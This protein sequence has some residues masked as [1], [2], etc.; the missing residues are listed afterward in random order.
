MVVISFCAGATQIFQGQWMSVDKHGNMTLCD[1]SPTVVSQERRIWDPSEGLSRQQCGPKTEFFNEQGQV[2]LTVPFHYARNFHNGLAAV[3]SPEKGWFYINK[4]GRI[5]ISL[6]SDCSA[7]EDFNEGLAAV[8]LGGEN[9]GHAN[10]TPTMSVH[11]S[12]IRPGAKWAFIDTTGQIVIPPTFSVGTKQVRT[13][14]YSR[15]Y[16]T[17]EPATHPKFSEGLA[18]VAIGGKPGL[19][20]GFVDKKGRWVVE[21]KFIAT[22]DFHNGE[23]MVY[24]S[25]LRNLLRI[26]SQARS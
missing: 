6:P 3:Y 1:S 5:A 17:T 25:S 14:Y 24:I 4:S 10:Y 2:V 23:A 13:H 15:T 18:A 16:L 26:A 20:F 11:A 21:P 22:T 8:A 9:L 12:N 7:A 19:S